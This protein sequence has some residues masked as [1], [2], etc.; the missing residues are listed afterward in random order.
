[1]FSSPNCLVHLTYFELG[2]SLTNLLKSITSK[3]S[4]DTSDSLSEIQ[5]MASSAFNAPASTE[6]NTPKVTE[7]MRVSMREDPLLSQIVNTIMRDGKKKRAQRYL[8]EALL[9]VRARMHADPYAILYSVIEKC[10]PMLKIAMTRKGSKN[11]PVPIPLNERQ[12]RR[13]AIIWILQAAEKRPERQFPKRLASEIIAVHNGQSSALEN[14]MR[15]H[16]EALAARAN[17]QTGTQ[18]RTLTF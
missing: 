2:G 1:V 18:S 8:A 4:N 3:Q 6:P 15:V 13:R 12:R 14:R 16:K 11:I 9:E 7:A 5:R 10:S 17:V